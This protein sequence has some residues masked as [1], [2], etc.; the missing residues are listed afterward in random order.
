VRA[1]RQ[2]RYLRNCVSLHEQQ[3]W[4][5][6]HR[7]EPK[8]YE[9]CKKC[10]IICA[11][12][13][14][15]TRV[16]ARCSLYIK[17]YIHTSYLSALPLLLELEAIAIRCG[18]LSRAEHCETDRNVTA[19]FKHCSSSAVALWR[20][21]SESAVTAS[22]VSASIS[23]HCWSMNYMCVYGKIHVYRVNMCCS[24]C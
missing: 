14:Y 16:W 6:S 7:S 3:H 2:L 19:S 17:G 13:K 1:F 4:V 22:D 12:G 24:Y 23:S 21:A 5:S 10:A 8:L 18:M 20:S 15:T 11:L 9:Y